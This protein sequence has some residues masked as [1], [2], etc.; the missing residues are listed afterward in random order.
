[1]LRNMVVM[2]G[3]SHFLHGFVLVKVP[4]PLTIGFKHMFQRELDL[5]TLETSYVS[6]LS[7]YFLVMFGLCDFF[8]MAISDPSTKALE[9][10]TK[11]PD[12]GMA[13]GPTPVGPHQFVAPKSLITEAYKLELVQQRTAVN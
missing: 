10:K 7:W 12:M 11:H 13:E 4:F 5:S 9:S 1:M 3:V 6:S 2:K 8:R